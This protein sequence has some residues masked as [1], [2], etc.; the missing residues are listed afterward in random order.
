VTLISVFNFRVVAL[1]FC[2]AT[3]DHQ[4]VEVLPAELR[5][6]LGQLQSVDRRRVPRG[7]RRLQVCRSQP[8]R[9]GRLHRTTPRHS[10]VLLDYFTYKLAFYGTFTQTHTHA[11]LRCDW[12]GLG[13]MGCA[14]NSVYF[15]GGVHT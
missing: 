15:N 12:M 14:G 13:G 2:V 8:G 4:A 9:R 11:A 6:R 1:A 5:A 10:S 7:R 3:A